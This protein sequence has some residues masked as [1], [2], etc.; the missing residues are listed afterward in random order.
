MHGQ[1]PLCRDAAS[2]GDRG[3]C[4]DCLASLGRLDERS[5]RHRLAAWSA[6]ALVALGLLTGFAYITASRG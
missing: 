3:P 2:H 1:C 4:L 5:Q 6:I